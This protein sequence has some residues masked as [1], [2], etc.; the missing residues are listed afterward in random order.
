MP[1]PGPFSI[2]TCLQQ[3]RV[4]HLLLG[5]MVSACSASLQGYD[6]WEGPCLGGD[7][8]G[9]TL[10]VV[11]V[12]SSQIPS[13]VFIAT[14]SLLASGAI[15]DNAL[16][17]SLLTSYAA[18]PRPSANTNGLA[19]TIPLDTVDDNANHHSWHRSRC[20]TNCSEDNFL[21]CTAPTLLR[22]RLYD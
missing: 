5:C 6:V 16:H 10:T 7:A 17:E 18:R 8:M 4:C 13:F 9:N 12:S 21:S 15:H 1:T 14:P 22:P 20:H 11:A 19:R 2:N 3:P